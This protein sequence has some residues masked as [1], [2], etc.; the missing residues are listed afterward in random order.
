NQTLAVFLGS[1]YVNDFNYLGRTYRAT[2]QADAAF[3]DDLP[4]IGDLWVRSM[5]G[6]MV[7]LSAV[8]TVSETAG[9][10]RVPRHNLFPAAE[11]DAEPAPGVASGQL[12]GQLEPL[13]AQVLPAG[14][15]YEWRDI[16]YIQQQESGGMV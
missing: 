8:V 6:E 10:Q 12:I 7:P 16:A 13:A 2:A 14:F 1:A 4:D 9:P 15:S 11:L 3:R 5:D